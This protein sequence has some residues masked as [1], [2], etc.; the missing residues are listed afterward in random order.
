MLL[1][2]NFPREGGETS[3]FFPLGDI[4]VPS[5]IEH[6]RTTLYEVLY[7]IMKPMGPI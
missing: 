4:T 1:S 6:C 7:R 2:E 3:I 5:P